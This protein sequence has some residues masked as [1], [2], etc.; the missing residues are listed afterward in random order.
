MARRRQSRRLED[1]GPHLTVGP[2]GKLLAH[3]VLDRLGGAVGVGRGS[4]G[5]CA[6]SATW[7][8]GSLS[9]A[10]MRGRQSAGASST[11]RERLAT[12]CAAAKPPIA[13]TACS[14]APA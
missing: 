8:V 9:A 10:T 13:R 7:K 6:E 12:R 14:R 2:L 3:I 1:R 4:S 11:R 5:G